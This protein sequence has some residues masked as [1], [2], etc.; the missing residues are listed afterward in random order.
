M[1][2]AAHRTSI[3]A[4]LRCTSTVKT[5]R[6][7]TKSSRRSC[8]TTA[9]TIEICRGRTC[10]ART[11]DATPR[12]WTAS[13]SSRSIT[14]SG[15]K[16]SGTRPCCRSFIMVTRATRGS[17]RRPCSSLRAVSMA[18]VPSLRRS[19]RVTAA[20]PSSTWSPP[21]T[22]RTAIQPA[23]VQ[24][25]ILPVLGSLRALRCQR[26]HLDHAVF[27]AYDGSA[28]LAD[29]HPPAPLRRA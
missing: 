27:S 18:R 24:P 2:C 29:E 22:G 11:F 19:I 5:S 14:A 12:R 15:A 17:W 28:R 23:R 7:S 20:A 8:I 25:G 6:P 4:S 9:T 26:E 16:T 13:T 1:T 3:S 10:G 21:C